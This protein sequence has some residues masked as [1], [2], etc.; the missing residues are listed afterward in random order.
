MGYTYKALNP[1][2]YAANGVRTP[3]RVGGGSGEDKRPA[4]NAIKPRDSK[5]GQRL[6]IIESCIAAGWLRSGR[7]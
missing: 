4:C 5:S 1:P 6:R 7:L 3:S 2:F